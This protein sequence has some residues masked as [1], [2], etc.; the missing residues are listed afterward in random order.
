M[1]NQTLIESGRYRTLQERAAMRER[2]ARIELLEFLCVAAERLGDFNRA[3]TLEQTR[4]GLMLK[5]AERQAAQERIDRLREQKKQ[6]DGQQK[7]V[8]QVDQQLVSVG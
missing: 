8:L 3:I 2:A 4:Q 5:G 7:P 6:A 1:I